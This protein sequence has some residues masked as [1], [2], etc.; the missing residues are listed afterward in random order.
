MRRLL[1]SSC[2]VAAVAAIVAVA[3]RP[4][5]RPATAH[6]SVVS[7]S[8]TTS[9]AA[10]PRPL[11]THPLRSDSVP[12]VPDEAG[13]ADTQ[14]DLKTSWLVCELPDG[15]AIACFRCSR[16]FQCPGGQGC[17]LNRETGS[18]ECVSS[19]CARDEDCPSG[20]GCLRVGDHGAV[21]R[22]VE[23]GS[24][25]LGERCWR[26]P[27][28]PASGCQEG[29]ICVHGVCGSPCNLGQ[30]GACP[31]THVCVDTWDGPACAPKSCREVGCF[32]KG[33]CIQWAPSAWMCG[34][35]VSGENCF[36][37]GCPD[38]QVC[39]VSSYQW[40]LSYRCATLCQP[41]N[42]GSC[43]AGWVCGQGS[44]ENE[45]VCYRACSSPRD[46]PNSEACA[47]ITEDKQTWGCKAN[48]V[49]PVMRRAAREAN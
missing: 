46:C 4:K 25:N 15:G 43:P 24:L 6:G 8:A 39:L 3:L 38:G 9:V 35:V 47:T 33:D 40:A 32:G 29:L 23:T 1:L 14:V 44:A 2:L 11:A 10:G 27:S 37:R 48:V 42:T 28:G 18:V 31:T 34:E 45:S 21:R 26:D 16:D 20:W 12:R 30:A 41:L 19:D 36:E 17:A 13:T 5:P 7:I 22:C 49:G